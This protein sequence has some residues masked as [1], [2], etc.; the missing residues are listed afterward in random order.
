M[1]CTDF[2]TAFDPMDIEVMLIVL[3]KLYGVHGRVLSWC[4]S[5]LMK[6]QAR[7]KIKHELS[8]ESD[9]NFSVPQ[10]SVLGPVLFNLYI[11]ILSYEIRDLPLL[12]SGYADDHGACNSFN[13]NSR[14]EEEYSNQVLVIPIH[15]KK[16]V[17]SKLFKN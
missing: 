2:S 5:Y 6:R 15:Y 8:D 3:E 11:S 13:S 16:L 1:L 7:V 4:K 12:L 10:G 9:I 17:G 14:E